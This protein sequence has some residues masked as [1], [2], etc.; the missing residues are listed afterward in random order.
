V[1]WFHRVFLKEATDSI[2]WDHDAR[3]KLDVRD[4]LTT[5]EKPNLT[6]TEAQ[7]LGSFFNGYRQRQ[8]FTIRLATF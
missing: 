2:S 8:I 5:H 7:N 6:G 1:A 3:S 4:F